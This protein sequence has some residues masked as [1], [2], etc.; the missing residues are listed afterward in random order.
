MH[1]A[2]LLLWPCHYSEEIGDRGSSAAAFKRKNTG[3]IV[4]P[5][6]PKSRRKQERWKRGCKSDLQTKRRCARKSRW[7]VGMKILPEGKEWSMSWQ[8]AAKYLQEDLERLVF[9]S[10][11]DKPQ[12]GKENE[13]Q[14][15]RS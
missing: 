8:G 7:R 3:S 15:A 14:R 10:W 11:F 4:L 9:T 2:T 13:I 6:V 12:M 5:D 1:E